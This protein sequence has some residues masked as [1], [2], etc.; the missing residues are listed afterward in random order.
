MNETILALCK[1]PAIGI[2]MWLTSMC[3]TNQALKDA[4][5]DMN[6]EGATITQK[7]TAPMD[8]VYTLSA[9]LAST[10]N[11]PNKKSWNDLLCKDKYTISISIEIKTGNKPEIYREIFLPD[12]KAISPSGDFNSIKLGNINLTKGAHTITVSNMRTIPTQDNQ[13]FQLVLSGNKSA[14]FP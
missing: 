2:A 4:Y 12:C 6:M 13:K 8:E 10:N 7:Y 14:G 5:L 3:A 1:K 11:E 9:H